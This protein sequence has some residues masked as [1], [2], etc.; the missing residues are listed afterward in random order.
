MAKSTK[1][2]K[3]PQFKFDQLKFDPAQQFYAT[4]GAGDLA[5]EKARGFFAD[6]PKQVDAKAFQSQLKDLPTDVKELPS[7]YVAQLKELQ[8]DLRTLLAKLP[9]QVDAK[10]LQ[11]KVEALVKDLPGNLKDLPSWYVAQLKELQA[12]VQAAS[13]KAA[14]E[15]ASN[16]ADYASRGEKVVQRVRGNS[17]VAPVVDAVEGL[18]DNVESLFDKVTPAKAPAKKPAAKKAPATKTAAKK[19]PA[20]KTA[21]KKTTAKKAAAKTA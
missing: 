5:V 17:Y 2:S 14:D 9:S 18:T 19:A 21:A 6:L 20:K 11:G 12:S 13:K 8:A 16:L 4:V 10:A 7:R 15:R 3:F 1:A